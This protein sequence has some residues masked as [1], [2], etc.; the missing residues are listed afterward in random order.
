LLI[1]TT[2]NLLRD[3]KTDLR[4]PPECVH[5][6]LWLWE[7]S[8]SHWSSIIWIELVCMWRMSFSLTQ[9]VESRLAWIEQ[10]LRWTINHFWCGALPRGKIACSNEMDMFVTK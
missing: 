1:K 6:F 9:S 4:Q 10:L 2:Q 3:S 8:R 5:V 7:A